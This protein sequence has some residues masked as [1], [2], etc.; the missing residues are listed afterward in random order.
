MKVYQFIRTQKAEFTVIMLC[1]VCEVARSAYLAWEESSGT[2]PSDASLD[3]AYLANHIY[4]IWRGSRRRYGVPR[5]TAQLARD[6]RVVNDKK[7]SRIMSELGIAGICG[8]RKILTTRRDPNAKLASDLVNRNF[9]AEKPDVLWVGDITYI[10]T[11]EGWLYLASVLDVFSRRL[12]GWSLADHMMTELCLDALHAASATRRRSRFHGTIFHTD[13]G[14]Q[15]TSDTF[16]KACTA[17]GITQSMGSVGDSYDNALAESLWSSL[18]RE[19]FEG[20]VYATKREART[21]VFEWIMWYNSNRLHSSLGYQPPI[22][23][24]ESVVQQA[25]A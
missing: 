23:F 12:I 18:K 14:C 8:R 1:R 9:T 21:L 22:E 10:D 2:G 3:E 17:M 19:L 16:R 6:S 7:V 20:Q 25:A 24:E 13:H 11:G 15:Y 5:V 4:D